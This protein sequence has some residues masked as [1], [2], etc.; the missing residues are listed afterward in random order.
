S[1][2]FVRVPNKPGHSH[3]ALTRAIPEAARFM[4][5]VDKKRTS[6]VAQVGSYLGHTGRGANL[7]LTAA[8]ADHP[9]V[10]F[11]LVGRLGLSHCEPVASQGARSG[12]LAQSMAGIQSPHMFAYK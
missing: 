10:P 9:D 4:N 12:P 11:A 5:A 7:V 1:G 3:F 6:A 8:H 2:L